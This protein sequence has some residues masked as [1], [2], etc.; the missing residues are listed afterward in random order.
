MSPCPFPTTITI[1]P[2]ALQHH[3][4]RGILPPA[5]TLFLHLH[6]LLWFL[7]LLC[8]INNS[9]VI[10]L[11]TVK[12][13][14]SSIWPIDGTLIGTTTPDQNGPGSNANKRVL[15]IPWRS[16][17][18]TL[19]SDCLVS[20]RDPRGGGSLT[21]LKRCNRCILQTRWLGCKSIYFLAKINMLIYAASS[22]MVLNCLFTFKSR[23]S[24]PIWIFIRQNYSMSESFIE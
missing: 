1:T 3:Y 4:T 12:W 22:W 20:Y 19:Q 15:C 24:S 10:F 17:N 7:V 18:G 9:T 14:N 8:N 11:H 6:L 13:L 21:R 5:S 2:R 16:S 23:K